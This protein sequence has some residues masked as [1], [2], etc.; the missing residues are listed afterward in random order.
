MVKSAIQNLQG[1]INKLN[2]ER[3]HKSLYEPD[4][5]ED[6]GGKTSMAD[7]F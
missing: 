4:T 1:G 6:S 3:Q 2:T 5:D 7:I